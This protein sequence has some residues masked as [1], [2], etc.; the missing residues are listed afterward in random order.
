MTPRRWVPRALARHHPGHLD[1][2]EVPAF[3]GDEPLILPARHARAEDVDR[4]VE[5]SCWPVGQWSP[6]AATTREV[7]E[8]GPIG[9]PIS[10]RMDAAVVRM[11]P[12]MF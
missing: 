10:A 8:P 1:V 12:T 3:A 11:A 5:P 7:V 9:C 2:V 4:H 6:P